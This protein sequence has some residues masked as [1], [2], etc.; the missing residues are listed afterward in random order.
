MQYTNNVKLKIKKIEETII[1]KINV[2]QKQRVIPLN[3]FQCWK[4]KQLDSGMKH[5]VDQVKKS[6]PEFKHFL[7]DDNQCRDY[8]AQNC[9]PTV[10]HAYDH[11]IPGAYK[12]DLWRLCI[13]YKKGGIYLDIKLAPINGFKLINMTDQEHF[14]KDRLPNSIYNAFMVCKPNNQFVFRCINAILQ[15]VHHKHYGINPL[16]PTGPCL[17]GRVRSDGKFELNEDIV[18]PP[19]GGKIIYKN[20]EIFTTTYPG[21]GKERLVAGVHY[22]KLWQQKHIYK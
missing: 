12:A 15:N 17:L 22:D 4:T 7:Y 8:L 21:Y 19:E 6:S 5:A 10:L 20:Q 13:L 1:T 16:C 14:V 3:I 18:H 2:K 11:L 9:H